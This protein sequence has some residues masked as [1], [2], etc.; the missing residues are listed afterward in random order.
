MTRVIASVALSSLVFASTASATT[1]TF[2]TDPFAG[3]TA[4]TT[5]GR[6]IVGGETFITFNPL[7]DNFALGVPGVGGTVEFA[8]DIIANLPAGNVNVIVLRTFDDDANTGTPFG[9]GNA[10]SLIAGQLTSPGPGF[11]IYFNSTLDVPRLVYSTNLDDNTA[12][13]KVL[14]RMTNLAGAPG[15]AALADFTESNFAFVASEV[16]E[17]SSVTLMGTGLLAAWLTMRRRRS[18]RRG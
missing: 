3:S 16:P 5:P 18:A 1:F 8:N 2:N 13:L 9:A 7:T 15:R 4:L 10:A 11:F 12:D 17:P 14:F 6:Q